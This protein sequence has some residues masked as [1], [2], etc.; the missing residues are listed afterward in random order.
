MD[1]VPEDKAKGLPTPIWTKYQIICDNAAEKQVKNHHKYVDKHVIL[2]WAT[3]FM[4][5]QIRMY[6]YIYVRSVI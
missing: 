5:S 3:S 2:N 6:K 1:K 4:S